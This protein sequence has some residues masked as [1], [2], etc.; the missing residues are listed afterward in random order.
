MKQNNNFITDLV[1]FL[2]IPILVI[3]QL[4]ILATKIF[5][6]SITV[7]FVVLPALGIVKFIRR[8]QAN[9]TNIVAAADT[10][11]STGAQ[12]PQPSYVILGLLCSVGS[13]V[14]LFTYLQLINVDGIGESGG[15][16][17]LFIPLLLSVWVAPG[18]VKVVLS[19]YVNQQRATAP[20]ILNA[21]LITLTIGYL[22]HAAE[23]GPGEI[24]ILILFLPLFA[25]LTFL[26]SIAVVRLFM[27]L[28]H[29]D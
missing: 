11:H 6:L 14:A 23:Q 5:F 3:L 13:L 29:R 21:A 9:K 2:V 8:R 17:I 10:K 28:R 22:L 4:S 16:L 20:L 26:W 1:I 19:S 27:H 15:L 7:I 12:V 25:P 24:G 18:L